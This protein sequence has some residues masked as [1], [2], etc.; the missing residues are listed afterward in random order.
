MRVPS[1][2]DVTVI[3]NPRFVLTFGTPLVASA[4]PRIN[5]FNIAGRAL[6]GWIDDA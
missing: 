4:G 1:V 3:M 2:K 5:L 6:S